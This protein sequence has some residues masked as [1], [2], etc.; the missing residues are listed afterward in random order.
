MRV[1][2]DCGQLLAG[3]VLSDSYAE[4]VV[5]IEEG[6]WYGPL[7][8]KIGAIDTYGNPNTL[9]MDIPSSEL[10]QATSAQTCLVDFEKFQGELPPVTSFGGPIEVS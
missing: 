6:A 5:R 9:T 8:E 2:N 4:G 10:A 3:A 1:F 7:N